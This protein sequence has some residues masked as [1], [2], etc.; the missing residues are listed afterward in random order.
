MD[1]SVLKSFLKDE[2]EFTTDEFVVLLCANDDVTCIPQPMN[3]P[4]WLN[5][6]DADTEDDEE[7][8][9]TIV[10]RKKF[11]PALEVCWLELLLPSQ[12][13]D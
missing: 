12:I 1:I 3:L 8:H 7:K 11:R 13:Y 6:T 2:L 5:R 9:L 4:K 10:R